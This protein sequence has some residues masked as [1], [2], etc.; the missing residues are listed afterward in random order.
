MLTHTAS[1][2]LVDG[3][4][5]VET[6]YIVETMKNDQNLLSQVQKYP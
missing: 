5:N 4:L 6:V 2:K 3:R 1:V